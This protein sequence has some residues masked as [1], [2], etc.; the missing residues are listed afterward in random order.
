MVAKVEVEA[1]KVDVINLGS[2]SVTASHAGV[3][4]VPSMMPTAARGSG[5]SARGSGLSAV[6]RLVGCGVSAAAW[7]AGIASEPTV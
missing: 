1:V 2:S 4:S 5:T 3:S 7:C 6:D